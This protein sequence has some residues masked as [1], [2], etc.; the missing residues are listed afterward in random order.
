MIVYVH[1]RT[2]I[3]RMCLPYK[4]VNIWNFSV[5]SFIVCLFVQIPK[6]DRCFIGCL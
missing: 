1:I 4:G 6:A 5:A 3:I 2:S